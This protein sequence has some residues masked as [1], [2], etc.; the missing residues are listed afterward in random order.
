MAP[1][2]SSRSAAPTVKARKSPARGPAARKP[3]ALKALARK[4]AALKAPARK[5]APAPKKSPA[6]KKAPA[7]KPPAL[8]GGPKLATNLGH[9]VDLDWLKTWP[10]IVARAWSDPAF[11]DKLKRA[12]TKVFEEY[13]LP[14]FPDFEYAIK[15]G[16][17]RPLVTLSV[18]PRPAGAGQESVSDITTENGNS[19]PQSCTNTCGF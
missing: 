13:G 5:K 17:G 9:V 12:P 19:R 10:R 14:L 4:A 3:P 8:R 1:K 15:S 2:K 16:A 11:M 6:R 7:R 18:P